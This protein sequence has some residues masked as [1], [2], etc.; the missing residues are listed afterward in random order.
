MFKSRIILVL[1][2]MNLCCLFSWNAFLPNQEERKL[3]RRMAAEA[4]RLDA[5][6][7]FALHAMDVN[8]ERIRQHMK[9]FQIIS[10]NSCLVR[11]SPSDEVIHVT[12]I[13]TTSLVDGNYLPQNTIYFYDKCTSGVIDSFRDRI[14]FNRISLIDNGG[15]SYIT[16]N[17]VKKT[18][19]SYKYIPFIP[20]KQKKGE[21]KYLNQNISV[22]EFNLLWKH[23]G[24][25]IYI[26]KGKDEPYGIKLNTHFIFSL[27]KTDIADQNQYFH[28]NSNE[29]I[30]YLNNGGKLYEKGLTN[31][32]TMCTRCKGTGVFKD[33]QCTRCL[34]KKKIAKK[35]L[36]YNLV[37]VNSLR[38]FTQKYLNKITKTNKDASENEKTL[39]NQE[40]DENIEI[41]NNMDEEENKDDNEMNK[42]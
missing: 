34:G 30:F 33:Q 15:Y 17:N 35:V 41:N 13:D 9:I 8:Y 5:Q 19:K 25:N 42:N 38:S 20:K 26:Y 18:I 3:E 32:F 29:F 39:E 31:T 6:L 11:I 28:I 23:F 27:D 22:D 40:Q 21:V 12:G 14:I 10:E 7:P 24:Y 1:F 2:L 36:A 16:A 37:T 4:S